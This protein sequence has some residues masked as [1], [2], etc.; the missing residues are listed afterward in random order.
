MEEILNKL[1][2]SELL[3][4]ETKAQL[5]EQFDAAVKGMKEE[6][7][8]EVR[9]ELVEQYTKDR[10]ALVE[11]VEEKVEAFLKQEMEE[12]NEDIAAFRDLEVEKAAELVEAKKKL[13]EQ[14][15]EELD[16][17]VDKID[18]FLEYRI[19]EEMVE[20]KEDLEVVKQNTFGRKIFESFMSEFNRSF[21]DEE[22]VF[23]KMSVL[24]DKL[25]DAEARLF[26][27]EQAEK[28]ANRAK[29][30]DEVLAPLA[31]VKREQMALILQNVET[32]K[33]QEAYNRFVGR[34][35]KEE[36]APATPV[37]ESAPAAPAATVVKTGDAPA[38][39]EP[40]ATPAPAVLKESVAQRM[41][42]LAG[43]KAQ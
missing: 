1:L 42:S 26:E 10:E 12:L 36:A 38:V 28:K 9:A 11:S 18:T 25:Q 8:L 27:A 34:I 40:V 17:I 6:L 20:L 29:K 19:E 33:L 30:L 15:G 16:Q 32:S 24:E 3:S 22:S 43:V 14:L 31:G 41:L 37:V 13:A 35:L 23:K 21:V 39:E 5:K 7:T 2:E 4:E